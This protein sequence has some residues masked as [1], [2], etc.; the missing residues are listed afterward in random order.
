[1]AMFVDEVR[2]ASRIQHPNVVS[3]LDVIEERGELFLVMEYVHG[4]SLAQLIHLARSRGAHVPPAV[5]SAIVCG[6]LHGLHAA[7]EALSETGQP[8]GIIHR[9]VSPQ[10]VLVGSDGVTRVLD[11]GIATATGRLQ[12]TT[13]E[14]QL[15]GKTAYLA[16]ERIR[17]R[18]ADRRTDVYGAALA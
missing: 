18:D 8:L 13:R 14:G 11:F 6:L 9:D 16:P 10:N 5:A 1:V 17:G 2:L 12:A 4:E 3:T 15:K 7:H